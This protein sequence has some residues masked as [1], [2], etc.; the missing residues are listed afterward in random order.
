MKKLLLGLTIASTFNST[1]ASDVIRVILD[2]DQVV[3]VKI[4]KNTLNIN[5]STINLSMYNGVE[6]EGVNFRDLNNEVQT[7]FLL[8]EI[9]EDEALGMVPYSVFGFHTLDR[10][11]LWAKAEWDAEKFNSEKRPGEDEVT[12]EDLVKTVINDAQNLIEKVE[13]RKTQNQLRLIK[14]AYKC[15]N[16][17]KEES[18][19]LF[20]CSDENV[21]NDIISEIKEQ[22]FITYPNLGKAKHPLLTQEELAKFK[23]N[24][25]SRYVIEGDRKL[26]YGRPY[27]DVSGDFTGRIQDKNLIFKSYKESYSMTMRDVF[28]ELIGVRKIS[29]EKGENFFG[30][31]N[32]CT[33]EIL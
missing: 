9:D 1:Y 26:V 27:H 19:G 10:N 20:T 29:C 2:K 31:N 32:S 6:V 4:K 23:E 5:Y 22:N 16:S 30:K 15:I 21:V 33:V 7:R 28:S 24:S 3:D 14:T 8:K 17:G 11:I 18:T 13:K 25:L 12:A